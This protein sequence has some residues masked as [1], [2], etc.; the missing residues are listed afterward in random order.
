MWDDHDWLGDNQDS[1]DKGAAAVAKQSYT[2]GI[3]HYALGSSLLDETHSA[4]YQAFTIGTVRFI[5]T[6]LRS[7]SVRST[8]LYSGKMYSQQQKEWFFNKLSQA[9][10]FDYVVWV[11][12]RP[13]TDSVEVGLDSWGGFVSDCDEL[14]SHIAATIETGPRNLLVLSG[15]NHMVA[16]NDGSNTDFSGQDDFPG[17]FPLLH[18]G[19]TSNYGSGLYNFSTRKQ[20][21]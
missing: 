7:E 15:D 2:L 12:T 19:P 20:T 4:K 18:S 6:D 17:G 16:F 3:P 11:S 21:T 14:S 9:A 5:M 1:K 13:W 10:E 8:E